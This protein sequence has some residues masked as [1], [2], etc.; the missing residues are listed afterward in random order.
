[1]RKL[2]RP[3][4][5]VLL[6]GQVDVSGRGADWNAMF[7][8]HFCDHFFQLGVIRVEVE[9]VT[10]NARQTLFRKSLQKRKEL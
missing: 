8:Q 3:R 10:D 6:C 4:P 9:H 5:Q 1:M 7:M 2:V